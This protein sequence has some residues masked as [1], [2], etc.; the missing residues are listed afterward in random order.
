M[1]S[2]AQKTPAAKAVRSAKRLHVVDRDTVLL[3]I[4]PFTLCWL[5]AR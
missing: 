4:D 5:K 1:Q 2:E 3:N